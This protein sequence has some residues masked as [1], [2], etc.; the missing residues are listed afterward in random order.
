MIDAIPD[1]PFTLTGVDG[2]T[3]EADPV[4]VRDHIA[5]IV[6]GVMQVTATSSKDRFANQQL[7]QVWSESDKNT[8][9][10]GW[11]V[12]QAMQLI[13]IEMLHDAETWEIPFRLSN[14]NSL[15]LGWRL[16]RPVS[17]DSDASGQD[18]HPID[19]E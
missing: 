2:S 4:K 11:L 15:I 13:A 1:Q 3:Y 19:E 9:Y 5:R 18:A 17:A 8:L 7:W 6:G 14:I 12:E 16:I 10:V